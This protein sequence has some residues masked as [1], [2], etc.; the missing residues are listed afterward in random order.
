M[1]TFR[2]AREALLLANDLDLIDDEEMLLLFDFNT[3]K[4]LDIPHWKYEK[5]QLN[6]LGI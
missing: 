5:F 3:S 1:A 2:E 4:N 6:S